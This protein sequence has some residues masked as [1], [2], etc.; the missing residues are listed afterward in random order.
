MEKMNPGSNLAQTMNKHPIK[1]IGSSKV[2]TR[3]SIIR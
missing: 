3:S 1:I 2:P